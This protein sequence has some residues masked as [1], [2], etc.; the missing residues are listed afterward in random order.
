MFKNHAQSAIAATQAQSAAI[1]EQAIGDALG[2][3]QSFFR[4]DSAVTQ[5]KIV[6]G[7]AVD[8]TVIDDLS[9]RLQANDFRFLPT[10]H[11]R[12]GAELPGANGAYDSTNNR[13]LISAEF[14]AS[15]VN[16]PAAIVNLLLEEIGHK[17]DRLF[18]AGIDS[19]G[20]EGAIFAAIVQ[21]QTLSA[22]T[23]AQLRSEDDRRIWSIDGQQIDV[24]LETWTGTNGPDIYNGTSGN[25]TADGLNGDD[26]LNGNAGDDTLNGGNGQDTINGGDGNDRILG[27]DRFVPNNLNGDAGNDSI[28]STYIGDRI[29]GGT[30]NDLL[31]GG[32]L[33][34]SSILGVR[35]IF[36]ANNVAA[37]TTTG[38]FP[39][40]GLI[41]NIETLYFDGTNQN[42]VLD[43]SAAS[44]NLTQQGFWRGWGGADLLVGGN[45]QEIISGGNGDDSLFGGNGDDEIFGDAGNDT[46]NGDGGNDAL[47]DFAGI[48]LFSGG[49]GDDILNGGIDIDTA[50][51][52]GARNTYTIERINNNEWII[53]DIAPNTD[54]DDGQDRLRDIEILQFSGNNLIPVSDLVGNLVDADAI[55]NSITENAPNGT[56]ISGLA[57]SL[58]NSNTGT[59]YSLFDNAGGRFAINANSGV[60]TVADSTGL[61]YEAQTSHSITVQATAANGSFTKKT[62]TIQVN[63]V[64]FLPLEQDGMVDLVLGEDGSYV[65]IDPTTNTSIGPLVYNNGTTDNR[66]TPTSYPGWEVVGAERVNDDPNGTIEYMWQNGSNFWYSTNLDTGNLISDNSELMAKEFDFEQDFN[67]DGNIGA[68]PSTIESFGQIT[69]KTNELG[70]YIANDGFTDTPIT[71]NGAPV[72]STTFA[73]WKVVG[74]ELVNDLP[75]INGGE[76]AYMWQNGSSFWYSTINN[77]GNPVSGDDLLFQETEFEQDFNGDGI[78][79]LINGVTIESAGSTTL[80]GNFIGFYVANNGG[81][82][83]E[84]TYAD[85]PIGPETYP[86]WHILGAEIDGSDVKAM[87]RSNTGLFWYSTNNNS[88]SLVNPEAYEFTF[89]QDFDND[90]YITQIGTSGNDILFGNG[91]NDR[92]LSGTGYDILTGG[93]GNDLFVYGG[94]VGND[95]ITINDFASGD[96]LDITSLGASVNSSA[97]TF[98]QGLGSALVEFN[99]TTIAALN[100]IDPTILNFNNNLIF[101]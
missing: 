27:G 85:T 10:I 72:D 88:G 87:W 64:S 8:V 52:N 99:G 84:I 1:L 81:T 58:S 24:E 57:L 68:L 94:L 46:L 23:L 21:G 18:N 31:E 83:I 50:K 3:I 54:G 69:L 48:N 70:F 56:V 12:P 37:P 35:I 101:Y 2:I 91:L 61:D 73:G 15:N 62:F 59:I 67:G 90:G 43:A 60:V 79:G 33:F 38:A 7:E 95:E 96:L 51:Y 78:T 65:A 22:E 32:Y 20:D 100:G 4:Q 97:I 66:I 40:V 6:F 92:F 11:V 80:K 71:Y 89:Q 98:S 26:T 49:S 5:L 55:T 25:D 76:V 19:P 9:Q 30:E 39:V 16:H 36:D 41:Q 28:D 63:D 82:D 44:L 47:Q 17:L 86:G 74:A 77:P 13:I 53:T 45:G 29:D 93:D 14:L 42:D 34:F 75:L